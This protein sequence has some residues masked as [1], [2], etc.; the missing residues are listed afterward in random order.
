[1]CPSGVMEEP[2]AVESCSPN[3]EVPV[4]RAEN[5]SPKNT[6]AKTRKTTPIPDESRV[7]ST[8]AMMKN[9]TPARALPNA[10]LDMNRP[11]TRAPHV[12][13]DPMSRSGVIPEHS[14]RRACSG[15]A[16]YR[17]DTDGDG[18]RILAAC[19]A[20]GAFWNIHGCSDPTLSELIERA[21][22]KQCARV[23][24]VGLRALTILYRL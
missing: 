6:A 14:R 8:I 24:A 5:A 9:N 23:A 1:M 20:L 13:S 12:R 4:L 18:A 17:A 19:E 11:Y 16:L 15:E 22:E 10:C 3:Y 7:K 2:R 21:V